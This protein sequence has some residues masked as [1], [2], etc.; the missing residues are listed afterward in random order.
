M[1]G[2]NCFLC[3]FV[4]LLVFGISAPFWGRLADSRANSGLKALSFQN[5]GQVLG[6]LVD[7]LVDFANQLDWKGGKGGT[8][9]GFRSGACRPTQSPSKMAIFGPRASSNHLAK[10][11]WSHIHFSG[12]DAG[13]S[14]GGQEG[15]VGSTTPHPPHRAR[16][17]L[18]PTLFGSF[19][20]KN[21]AV[22]PEV[23]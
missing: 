20:Q 1:P 2:W 23:F 22:H 13:W 9:V 18:T 14:R 21:Q 16:K 8:R 6:G 11:G 19:C 3:R 15:L 17:D 10:P 5:G 7:P 4:S 12:K